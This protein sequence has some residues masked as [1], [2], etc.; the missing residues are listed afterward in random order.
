MVGLVITPSLE[1]SL[2]TKRGIVTVPDEDA[3]AS[4]LCVSGQNCVGIIVNQLPVESATLERYMLEMGTRFISRMKARGLEPVGGD[5]RLHGPW[6]SYE[7]SKTAADIESQ[8]WKDAE[9]EDDA[10]H[11]LPF[12]IEQPVKGAYSDYVL[13]GDFIA[14]N[15]WTEVEVPDAN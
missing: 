10:S 3:T 6:P 1:K 9:R 15:V 12:I 5:L 13:V 8:A 7:F 11:A 2:V 14:P 4:C